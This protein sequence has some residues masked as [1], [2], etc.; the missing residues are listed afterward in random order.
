MK[1]VLATEAV[2]RGLA[3]RLDENEELWGI[4]GLL[5]DL[6]YDYT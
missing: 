5:H 6:D 2:M 4:A 1:H 3:R